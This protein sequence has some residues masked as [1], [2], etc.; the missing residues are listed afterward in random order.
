MRALTVAGLSSPMLFSQASILPLLGSTLAWKSR[1]LMIFACS[2]SSTDSPGSEVMLRVRAATLYALMVCSLFFSVRS[3]CNQHSNQG[4]PER[5]CSR[6]GRTESPSTEKLANLDLSRSTRPPVAQELATPSSCSVNSLASRPRT[7]VHPCPYGQVQV[8][9]IS[10]ECFSSRRGE[11]RRL[12]Q[13]SEKPSVVDAGSLA[14]GPS[15][16]GAL[17]R[18]GVSS[19]LLEPPVEQA[20]HLSGHESLTDHR[21]DSLETGTRVDL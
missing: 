10:L 5:L 9:V 16:L 13:P 20:S 15:H 21:L 2:Q 14:T 3:L 18:L 8:I 19:S 4:S 17:A 12:T 6:E 7:A 1:T 11:S